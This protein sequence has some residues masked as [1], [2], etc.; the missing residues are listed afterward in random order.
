MTLPNQHWPA[1]VVVPIVL[2]L[3]SCG[4]GSDPDTDSG[5]PWLPPRIDTFSYFPLKEGDQWSY[6]NLTDGTKLAITVLSTTAEFGCMSQP[7][8][9]SRLPAVNLNGDV[10]LARVG[11]DADLVVLGKFDI[12]PGGFIGTTNYMGTGPEKSVFMLLP[13]MVSRDG[14]FYRTTLRVLITPEEEFGCL[15]HDPNAPT[16]NIS[17]RCTLERVN[18]PAFM[19]ETIKV[20]LS[21]ERGHRATLYF[22]EDIGIVKFSFSGI[23]TDFE[24][25][26]EGFVLR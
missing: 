13:G 15:P 26:L 20:V 4:V 3:G 16:L 22:A 5:Y 14:T 2:L 7:F 1:I 9:L 25:V 23:E 10:F 18:V 11:P 12:F 6:R 24:F 8:H 19:G 17:A 21:D